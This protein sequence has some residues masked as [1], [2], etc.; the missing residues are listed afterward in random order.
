MFDPNKRVAF[1]WPEAPHLLKFQPQDVPREMDKQSFESE[2]QAIDREF[3]L[4]SQS[5]KPFP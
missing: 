5:Q 1:I 3:P 2:D 4:K